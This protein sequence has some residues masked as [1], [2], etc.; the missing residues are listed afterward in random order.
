MRRIAVVLLT[1]LAL[2]LACTGGQVTPKHPRDERAFSFKE[3]PKEFEGMDL[4]WYGGLIEQS[5]E[6]SMT[7]SYSDEEATAGQLKEWW[8]K[9]LSDA[10]WTETARNVAGNGS[11]RATYDLPD[12]AAGTLTIRPEGTLWWVIVSVTRDG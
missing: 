5:G 4:P 12:G 6:Y 7:V 2:S 1:T 9:A 10:G 8:P 3:V 11:L